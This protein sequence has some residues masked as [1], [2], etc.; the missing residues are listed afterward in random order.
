MRTGSFLFDLH[1]TCC[2]KGNILYCGE[3]AHLHNCIDSS[4]VALPHASEAG[5]S[6]YVPNLKEESTP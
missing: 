3:L 4:T 5:L 1:C 6:T 2:H